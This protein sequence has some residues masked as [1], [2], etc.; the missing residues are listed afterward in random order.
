MAGFLQ[1]ALAR[2]DRSRVGLAL[3]VCVAMLW[4]FWS[5]PLVDVDEG[6][7]AEATREMIA[8]GN[9]V[10]IY[11]NGEPRTD[12]ILKTVGI[13]VGVIALGVVLRKITS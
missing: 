12:N 13:V 5:A 10:S 8:S 1:Q 2:V 11:L 6:A 9:Y 7:F 3:A 4:G